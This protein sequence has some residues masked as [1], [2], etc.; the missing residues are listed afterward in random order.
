MS[1]PTPVCSVPN[2][3]VTLGHVTVAD[4][5]VALN[6]GY[7]RYM[8]D[9]VV[10]PAAGI[11]TMVIA[12]WQ[13]PEASASLIDEVAA[14]PAVA[15]VCLLS[16]GAQPP[17]GDPRYD[18]IY[19]AAVRHDLPLV[20][21]GAPGLNL[22]AGAD[23]AAFQR[24]IESHSLGFAISNQ[25]QLTSLVLEGIPERFPSLRVVFEEQGLFWVSMMQYRLDEYFLKRRS[26]APLLRGCRASTSAST[27]TSARSRSRRRRTSAT[28]RWC[29]RRRAGTEH[30]LF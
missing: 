28:W 4:L 3:L 22:V 23:Y 12:C 20:L 18:P 9:R 10:D 27:S 16:A 13:D 29:S 5:V 19:E 7:I 26:E 30:F 14:H 24:L 1:A 11:Y 25:I 8:L 15:A 21:H 17:L 2:R 6:A